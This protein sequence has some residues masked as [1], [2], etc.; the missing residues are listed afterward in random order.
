ML[1]TLTGW[2]VRVGLVDDHALFRA[3]LAAV[4]SREPDIEVVGEASN[5]DEALALVR[6]HAIDLAI[7]DVLMPGCSG[8][9]IAYEIRDAAPSCRILGL[10]VID[11]PGLVANMFRAGAAGF[12]LKSQTP[13]EMAEAIRQVMSGV[14]Y[15]PP[16]VS[17]D[18]IEAELG[19][20]PEPALQRLTKREREIF[21][22]LIRGYS[23]HEIASRLFI[24]LRTVETHRQ[25][26]MKKLSSRS[27]LEMHR[28][29][30]RHGGI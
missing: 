25:R 4:L 11:D 14:R 15:L 17:R 21:E 7:V 24:A 1:P 27:I 3:G 18:S 2:K 6:T 13:A 8:I 16:S 10:S 30:V 22:L 12:A 26:V 19:T 23:N 9:S 20:E 29:A 28:M 5:R